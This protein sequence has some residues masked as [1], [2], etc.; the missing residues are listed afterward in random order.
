MK[1]RILIV[2]LFVVVK[3]GAQTSAF[4]AIDSLSDKGRYHLALK[5]LKAI[6]NQSFLS[7]YKTAVIYESID[8]Y[9]ETANYLE[10][11]LKFKEDNKASLKLAKVYQKL[12]K[13]NQSIAI[14]EKLLAKDSLNLI[15]EYQLG[16]LYL[17]YRK[18]KKA[19]SL[20]KDLIEKDS[21]NAHYSYQLGLAYA[22]IKDRDRMINS[23][24]ETY[25]KDSLHVKSIS[26]LALSFFKLREKDS[27]YLFINKGLAVAP[28]HININ[29]VKVNQL[30]REKKIKEIVPVLLKLDSIKPMDLFTNTMLGKVYYNLEDFDNAKL[31]FENAAELDATN[32]KTYTYLGHIGMKKEDFTKAMFNYY[33]A[34]TIGKEKRDE[35]YYGLASAYYKMKRPKMALRF[36]EKA[37]EENRKN[38]NAKFQVAKITD[39]L[40]K[41]KQ[42][43]Y[44]QYKSYN[45]RFANI[46]KVES[47]YVQK[48]ISEIKKD[49]FMRGEKLEE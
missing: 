28:N 17:Q 24:I 3:V 46:D 14:Y 29:K 12:S 22:Y 40:Y 44:K 42:M 41:D 1:K 48:R 37:F 4:S 13:S 47:D 23:F 26:K 34:T 5:K 8:N 39:D 9:K 15:L 25:K 33:R 31:R 36:Y 7:N 43:A 19:I 38:Y 30:Y 16:K 45:D 35:E 10:T 2:L 21:T 49:Y 6:K 32:Y 11:A 18:S 20:F 27:T